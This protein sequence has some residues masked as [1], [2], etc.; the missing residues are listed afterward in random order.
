MSVTAV[1]S[2]RERAELRDR[3][4]RA[5]LDRPLLLAARPEVA[6]AGNGRA[7]SKER[8]AQ[9]GRKRSLA[10]ASPLPQSPPPATRLHRAPAVRE[11]RPEP[12][13]APASIAALASASFVPITLAELEPATR[14]RA[15][16]LLARI[17]EESIGREE[18]AARVALDLERRRG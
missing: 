6:S 12:T 5:R 10:V 2:A 18:Q 9:V 13:T 3:V 4:A 7:D 8:S 14:A 15:L 1:Q 11:H 16:R 17:P